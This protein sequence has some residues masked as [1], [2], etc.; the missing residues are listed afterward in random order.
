MAEPLTTNRIRMFYTTAT[1]W[2]MPG[3][4]LPDKPKREARLAANRA[5]LEVEFDAWLAEHDREVAA[6][7]W[8]ECWQRIMLTD[9][10]VEAV[11]PYRATPASKETP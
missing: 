6:G 7:A 3:A 10:E 1:G 2:A 8:D 5:D 11:N 4:W 9:S